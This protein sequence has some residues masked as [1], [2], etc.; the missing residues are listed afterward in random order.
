MTETESEFGF[1]V[2][3]S[4]NPISISNAF[5]ILFHFFG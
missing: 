1:K 2:Q 5:A 3:H 4:T